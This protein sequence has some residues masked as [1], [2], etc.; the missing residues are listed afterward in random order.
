MPR[1]YLL[2]AL[3][4][5]TMALIVVAD[6]LRRSIILLDKAL[7]RNRDIAYLPLLRLPV[8]LFMGLV[9][10]LEFL[11]RHGYLGLEQ[12]CRQRRIPYRDLFM[13]ATIGLFDLSVRDMDTC[14]KEGGDLLQQEVL[15][16]FC[17]KLVRRN[18]WDLAAQ[19]ELIAGWTKPP[20]V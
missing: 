1:A 5:L 12:R 16:L 6:L 20:L 17:L 2:L 9:V 4:R 19:D 8:A 14:T 3:E 7:Q 15:L 11:V 18:G 13:I 10:G